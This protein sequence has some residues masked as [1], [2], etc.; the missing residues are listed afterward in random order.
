[1]VIPVDPMAWSFSHPSD[2]AAK[3]HDVLQTRNNAG[4]LAFWHGEDAPVSII[5]AEALVPAGRS[6]VRLTRARG[7]VHP[8]IHAEP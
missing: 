8:L 3:A 1:M 4:E 2:E 6:A 5:P 7:E